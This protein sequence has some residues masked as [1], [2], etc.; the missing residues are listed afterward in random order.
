MDEDQSFDAAQVDAPISNEP[1]P[2]EQTYLDLPVSWSHDKTEVWQSIPREARGYLT[3]RLKDSH[4]AITRL[5]QQVKTAEPLLTVAE[6]YKDAFERNKLSPQEG[7]ARLM[8]FEG[9]LA[10]DA[11]TAIGALIQQ[12][13]G[14]LD[15]AKLGFSPAEALEQERSRV[16]ALGSELEGFKSRFAALEAEKA[17][18][19]LDQ[20]VARFK[21]SRAA[22]SINVR[23]ST[24][25]SG[26]RTIDDDLQ[27]IARKRYG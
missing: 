5:G 23:S 7:I 17:K 20:K 15:F 6:Q 22:S 25:A 11:T 21:G 3:E 10:Q 4:T 9:W 8:Q 2:A 26:P 12:Y 24:V 16:A 1:A 19:A 18:Q 27:A 13:A 14:K